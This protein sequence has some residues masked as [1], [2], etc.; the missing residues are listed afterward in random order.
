MNALA[1]LLLLAPAHLDAIA[2]TTPFLQDGALIGGGTTWGPALIDDDGVARRVC[3]EA[4]GETPRFFH[5]AVDGRV[6]VGTSRGLL[7]TTDR[8]CTWTDAALV[9]ETT[10]AL[11]VAA[12]GPAPLRLYVVTA[13]AGG[14]NGLHVSD[15]DGATWTLLRAAEPGAV[16]T[17]VV[18]GPG[19]A[20]AAAGRDL[21]DGA[22][23]L[24][25]RSGADAELVVGTPWPTGA[26]AARALGF[27]ADRDVVAGVQ[28][29][30]GRGVL[31][32]AA[33]ADG[34]FALRAETEGLPTAWAVQGAVELVAVDGLRLL[35]DDGAGFSEVDGPARCLL[36][37][38]GDARLWACGGLPDGAHFFST[39]DGVLW[40][41][42]LPF[43]L[44]VE[45]ACPA[46]TDG[47]SACAYLLPDEDAGAP[48]DAGADVDAG[49]REPPTGRSPPVA[50]GCGGQAA[51]ALLALGLSRLARRGRRGSGP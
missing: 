32:E 2:G 45:R 27:A 23:F 11:A 50:C 34:A 7:A 25:T 4:I 28:L 40:E 51:P 5:R 43:G 35:R 29:D 8:G 10:A 42:A 3:E 48:D 19:G 1:A 26:V 17:S 20:V 13:T 46:G 21:D 31:V 41:A 12:D 6:L 36:R 49:D 9:G 14:T 44:V 24:W 39:Q 18:A 33:A 16:L 37:V 22:P 30:D 38:P 47:A 15:D